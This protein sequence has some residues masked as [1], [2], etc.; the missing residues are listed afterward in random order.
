ME[1]PI[2]QCITLVMFT[3]F[4][5]TIPAVVATML[6]YGTIYRKSSTGDYSNGYRI[7]VCGI[8]DDNTLTFNAVLK[9]IRN[10]QTGRV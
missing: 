7:L 8:I 1:D 9:C 10:I 2:P 5:A 6:V 3:K 4:T